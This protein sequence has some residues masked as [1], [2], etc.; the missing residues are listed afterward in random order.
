MGITLDFITKLRTAIDGEIGLCIGLDPVLDKLPEHI[1]SADQPLLAFNREI[2]ESTHDIAAA[3]KPNLAFY[4]ALGAEGLSQL[5]E[6]IRIIPD[7]CIIICDAKRGDIGNTAK[8]YAA[9]LFD[10]LDCDAATVNPYLGGDALEPF[11]ERGDKGAY[12]LAVTSNPGGA[13]LQELICNGEPLYKHVIKL[14]VKLNKLHNAGLV[15]GAT[16]PGIWA[17]L[18]ELSDGL[19]L[20]VP[21]IGAQGGDLNALKTALRRNPAPVLVN[22]SRSIIYASSGVDFSKVAREAAM[23]LNEQLN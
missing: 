19:P 18:L 8:A 15:V 9:S 5:E 1:R 10:R 16:K 4:E 12:V 6:T 20:L 23:N 2:I 3:Y 17:D 22:A 14:V 11:L 21:G 7:K 13:D